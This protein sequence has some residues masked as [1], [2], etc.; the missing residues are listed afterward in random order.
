MQ[1][2]AAWSVVAG[3]GEGEVRQRAT[4]EVESS[5]WLEQASNVPARGVSMKTRRTTVWSGDGGR[6]R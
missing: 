4:M 3:R 1:M 5:D 2:K 6:V